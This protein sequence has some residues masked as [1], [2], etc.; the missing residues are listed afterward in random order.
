MVAVVGHVGG[1]EAW[2]MGTTRTATSYNINSDEK[3]KR[4]PAKRKG[5]GLT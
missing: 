3:E 5:G 4:E 2:G 1:Q